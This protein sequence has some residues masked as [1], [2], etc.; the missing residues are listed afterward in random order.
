MCMSCAASADVVL[1]G[2]IV[3][4]AGLRVGLRMMR[5]RTRGGE[6]EVLSPGAAVPSSA[7][8]VD[9]VAD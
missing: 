4:A 2:G 9:D 6:R 1:G 5:D 3:G 7:A 8:R